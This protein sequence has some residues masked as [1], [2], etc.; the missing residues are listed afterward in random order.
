MNQIC[1][2]LPFF[3]KDTGESM[4]KSDQSY[5]LKTDFVFPN[6]FCLNQQCFGQALVFA[7]ID[8]L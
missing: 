1:A 6:H 4:A 2:C 7:G 8:G 5:E 3:G